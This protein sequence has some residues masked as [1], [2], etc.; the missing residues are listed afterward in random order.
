MK[1]YRDRN[2]DQLQERRPPRLQR[3][4]ATKRNEAI[5][6]RKTDRLAEGRKE[7]VKNF[8]WRHP[9][10]SCCRSRGSLMC[11]KWIPERDKNKEMESLRV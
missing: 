6:D 10:D 11:T 1:Q 5:S 7:K 4:R 3:R 2:K 9:L 8:H